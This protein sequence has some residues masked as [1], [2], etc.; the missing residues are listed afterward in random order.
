MA[1]LTLETKNQISHR[2]AALASLAAL[3]R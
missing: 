3:L 2:A 1:Q